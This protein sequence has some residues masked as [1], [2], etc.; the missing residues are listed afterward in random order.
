METF[1]TGQPA[2][3]TDMYNFAGHT[4]DN[5]SC[6]PDEKD[7]KRRWLQGKIFQHID[8]VEM[9]HIGVRDLNFSFN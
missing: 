5:S 6:Q 8:N 1:K 2:P 4:E 7:K 3:S 9:L